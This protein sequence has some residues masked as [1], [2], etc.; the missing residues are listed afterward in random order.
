V[1]RAEALVLICQQRVLRPQRGEICV[2]QWRSRVDVD[3]DLAL[4]RRSVLQDLG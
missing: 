4:V 2:I 1:D 3:V